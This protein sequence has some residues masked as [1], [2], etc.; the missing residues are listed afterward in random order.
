MESFLGIV[1]RRILKS[2]TP[3]TEISHLNPQIGNEMC[4]KEGNRVA[5]HN[6]ITC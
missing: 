5:C 1:G 2:M 3:E 6:D 4:E